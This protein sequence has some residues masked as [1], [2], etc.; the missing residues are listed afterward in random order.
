MSVNDPMLDDANAKILAD[1]AV[2]PNTTDALQ[3]KIIQDVVEKT[4]QR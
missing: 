3:V 2:D 1:L 4:N